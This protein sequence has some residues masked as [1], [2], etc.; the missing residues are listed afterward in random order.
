MLVHES[1][2]TTSVGS[3]K[4]R[5]T[6]IIFYVDSGVAR[7]LR[8]YFQARKQ[9][10]GTEFQA[11]GAVFIVWQQAPPELGTAKSCAFS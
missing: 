5:G 11:H 10:D 6:T 1:H 8:P 7:R 3:L 9:V 2:T 4:T